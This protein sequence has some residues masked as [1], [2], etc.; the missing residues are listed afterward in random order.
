MMRRKPV[1]QVKND[2]RKKSSLRQ[3]QQ[4]PQHI[5]ADRPTR[6]GHRHRNQPPRNHHAPNPEPRAHLV[7]DHGRRNFERE[8]AEKENPRPQ[9]EH[10]RRQPDLLVHGQRGEP[11]VDPIEKRYKIKQHQE[12]DQ[13][14]RNLANRTRLK[15]ARSTRRRVAHTL[16]L[17]LNAAS[18]SEPPDCMRGSF[19]LDLAEVRVL[20]T[21]DTAA[22]AVRRGT[23]GT[24]RPW[25]VPGSRPA[26]SG[27]TP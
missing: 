21:A 19:R 15:G 18:N 23:R 6:E 4:K 2:P 16:P 11:D 17:A 25:R 3:P 7:Q 27:C 5:K 24:P 8:V 14:P 20:P 12:R 10:L 13:A 1:A 26:A 9:P 22:R